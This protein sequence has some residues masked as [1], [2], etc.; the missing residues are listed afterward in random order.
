MISFIFS[1]CDLDT[2]GQKIYA[3]VEL[4]WQDAAEDDIY[5]I[6]EKFKQFLAAMSYDEVLINKIQLVEC[7][8]KTNE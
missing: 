7:E 5:E 6:T 2:H 1:N 4:T 3:N 8:E